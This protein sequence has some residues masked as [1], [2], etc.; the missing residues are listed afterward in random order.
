[1]S[2]K[3][4]VTISE[5][6]AFLLSRGAENVNFDDDNQPVYDAAIKRIMRAVENARDKAI[7][8]SFTGSSGCY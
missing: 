7:D 5:E 1:M 8:S 3:V 4:R 6:E 2:L